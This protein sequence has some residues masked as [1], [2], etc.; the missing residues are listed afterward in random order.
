MT[1]DAYGGAAVARG[2]SLRHRFAAP[3]AG[4]GAAPLEF[5][6]TPTLVNRGGTREA[7][8]VHSSHP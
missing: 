1:A 7:V 5:F 6:Y 4:A 3:G 2:R 8:A